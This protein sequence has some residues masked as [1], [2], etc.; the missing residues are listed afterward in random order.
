M[1]LP[2]LLV[3]HGRMVALLSQAWRM[4]HELDDVED[5]LDTLNGPYPFHIFDRCRSLL[6][7]WIHWCT[8]LVRDLHEAILFH[9]RNLD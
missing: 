3:M 4:R 2:Q 5:F 6:D 9:A 7:D 8:H 1:T